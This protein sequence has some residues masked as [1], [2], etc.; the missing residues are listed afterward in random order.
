MDLRQ[1]DE[2]DKFY[3]IRLSVTMVARWLPNNNM[4]MP[5][6][7]AGKPLRSTQLFDF[8]FARARQFQ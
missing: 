5:A 7:L 1:T 8:D 6:V 2:Y 4:V 3:P